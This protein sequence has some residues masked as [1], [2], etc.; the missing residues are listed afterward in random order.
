MLAEY[1]RA[2]EGVATYDVV[3]LLLFVLFFLGVLIMVARM[4]KEHIDRMSHLPLE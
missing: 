1:L 4:K 3:A 2:I